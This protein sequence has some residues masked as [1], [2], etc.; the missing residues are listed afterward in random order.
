MIFYIL[1]V[2]NKFSL[3]K[4]GACTITK[5]NISRN[6]GFRPGKKVKEKKVRDFV[7]HEVIYGNWFEQYSHG[8]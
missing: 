4:N 2:V 5:S 8:S 3:L 6:S 7:S 1:N